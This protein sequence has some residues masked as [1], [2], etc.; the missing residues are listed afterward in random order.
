MKTNRR[1]LSFLFFSLIG[2]EVMALDTYIKADNANIQY[3]GRI[4]FTNPQVPTYAFPGI[5]IKA[6]FNGTKVSAVIK[7]Y[8]LGGATTT[9]YYNVLIDDVVVMKLKVNSADT[10]YLL[11]DNL[12]SA[13][14]TVTLIKRTEASVGKSSFKGFVIDGT[15]L[16]TLPALTYKMEFIGDSWTCGYGNEV[17]TTSPNTGFHSIYEDNAT[18]YIL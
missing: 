9:N 18:I 13:D 12:T 6:K 5:T 3:M 16:L 4:D 8:S 17:S 11:A 1:I 10:L 2:L 15:A 14:H 7:D